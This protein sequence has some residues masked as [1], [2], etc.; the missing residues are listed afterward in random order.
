MTPK[1]KYKVKRVPWNK[2]IKMDTSV[3]EKIAIANSKR[4]WKESSK[5]K[6]SKTRTGISLSKEHCNSISKGL[7]GHI[8]TLK[9]RLKIS[10]KNIGNIGPM[11]GRKLSAESR[12]KIS[13]FRKGKPS[14]NKGKFGILNPNWKGGPT[15]YSPEFNATLKEIIKKRD[16]YRCMNP[17]CKNKSTRLSV[18]HINYD[19]KD[20]RHENLITLCVSCNTKANKER[21]LYKSFYQ[22][23][24]EGIVL[25]NTHRKLN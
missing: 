4:I 17:G 5:L 25:W 21:H 20:C 23:M 6:M 10:E 12:Q 1:K 18:H 24:M 14:P 8:V 9:T 13:D 15:Y 2:G 22:T 11:K 19:K 3:G 16:N 7:K